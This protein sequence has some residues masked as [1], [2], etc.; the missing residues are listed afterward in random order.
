MTLRPGARSPASPK[1]AS[2]AEPPVAVLT[3]TAGRPP[4]L[5]DLGRNEVHRRRA[6]EAGHEDVGR[7]VVDRLRLVELLHAAAVHDGDARGQRHGL[8]LVVR[9]IDGGLADP[10]VQL[11][12]LGA[13]V[14]A[15]LGV[16][17]GQRLVE[18]EQGGVAHERPAHGDALALAA[19]ELAGLA[20]QQR[21]DL[22]QRRDPLDRLLLRGL[23]HAAALHA[24]GDVL[25]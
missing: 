21:L 10:L 25:A 5:D 8:D 11:L 15:Q 23:G 6:H 16:E 1:S 2:V 4:S 13:H 20:L 7:A 14:D 19:G 9:D 3:A 12:D 22:Q 24:E 17:V 18:Q